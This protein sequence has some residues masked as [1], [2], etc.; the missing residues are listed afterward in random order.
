GEI[1]NIY[2]KGDHVRKIHNVVF[3]P[4][5]AV[6]EQ[7]QN[8]LE[9]IG[10]I[11]SDG[12]PILG[13]DARNL[14]E[15]VL[16]S[17][18]E[19]FLIP[20]HIWTPWFSVL[21]SKSGFDTIEQC[22][23]D[24][25]PH[26]FALETGLSSD[27]PMNWRLSQLDR[28]T[29]V[30]NSDAHSPSKLAREANLF[31][32]EMCYSNILATLKSGDPQKF[33]G[34]I[35]F[36][37]EEGK[38]HLDGHRKCS[39]RLSP[40]ETL[41]NNGLCPVCGKRVTV[42]VLNRV[43]ELA[44]RPENSS[45][46]NSKPYY[47]LIPLTEILAEILNVGPATKTV[48]HKFDKLLHK[49]G[50]EIDILMNIPLSAIEK[51]GDSLLAEAIRRMR[52]REVHI[53]AGYDGEFGVVKL[54]TNSERKR[55]ENQTA[56]FQDEIVPSAEKTANVSPVSLIRDAETPDSNQTEAANKSAA[57]VQ[58]TDDFEDESG[59]NQH[60]REAI[61]CEGNF[62]LIIAG[63]GTGKTRTLTWRI[64]TLIKDKG[65]PPQQMLA[66]TFTNRAAEEMRERLIDL[67]GTA[68]AQL[69]TIKTFHALGAFIL[70]N[71]AQ[72]LHYQPN[73]SLYHDDEKIQLLKRI[74]PQLSQKQT[75][76]LSQQISDAKNDLNEINP[77]PLPSQTVRDEHFEFLFQRYQQALQERLAFDFDDL[78]V[79]PINLFL[80]RPEI[81]QKYQNMFR[82]I[83]VDEFQDINFSQYFLL[84]Q[85]TT[86][87]TNLC[88]IGD[89]DQAIY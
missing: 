71:E 33:L 77:G 28:Y 32:D 49:L 13:L 30:S 19:S 27:P 67:L 62:L 12:R 2:K 72:L 14:L 84:Q 15:M 82:Y 29:L 4:S 3:F 5:I 38:Y 65:A 31:N 75:K 36:F 51:T 44:D 40:K 21:G 26:I 81:K 68:T 89:P 39:A 88:V 78:I 35:E 59:L 55:I 87:Q 54:F 50:P 57:P 9:K 17:H 61:Q 45:H 58:F 79:R 64:A 80:T 1:S 25:T 7:F 20:A 73:F 46:T 18:P 34:T 60:Q 56:I 52:Q 63:P 8:A 11:R 70:K 23:D 37:P 48:A 86:N 76:M 16:E 24:L 10:N 42:G 69:I 66:V 41:A 85:L 43:E 83:S 6:A 22:F 47:S 53:A 74:N